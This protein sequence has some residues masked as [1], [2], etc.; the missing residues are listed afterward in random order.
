MVESLASRTQPFRPF[1]YFNDQPT[2]CPL[3]L[4][5]VGTPSLP[6]AGTLSIFLEALL[7]LGEILVL[8]DQHHGGA[9]M[10]RWEGLIRPRE[11]ALERSQKKKSKK[12]KKEEEETEEEAGEEEGEVL[13]TGSS[14][15][16]TAKKQQSRD[17]R[18][19]AVT[20]W[21]RVFETALS[22]Q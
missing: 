18:S 11:I 21:M 14:A 2:C 9:G 6:V 20:R 7:L 16:S 17:C 13:R 5:H 10:R 3:P 12:Q 8:V 1:N 19:D 22:P 4:G 15:S